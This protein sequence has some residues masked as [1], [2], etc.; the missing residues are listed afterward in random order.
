LRIKRLVALSDP[1]CGHRSGITPPG[2]WWPLRG[3]G[4]RHY[5]AI[6]QRETWARAK[7]AAIR[8][9]GC[10]LVVVNGDAIEGPGEKKGGVENIT[11]NRQEQVKMAVEYLKL[12]NAK[13]YV[14]AFGTPYH[15]GLTEDWEA[16]VAAEFGAEIR[17]MPFVEMNGV[18]FGFRHFVSASSIPHGVFTP[19][20]RERLWNILQAERKEQPRADVIIRSHVHSFAHC[21][22]AEWRAI[23]TPGL[24]GFGSSYGALKVSRCIDWG[25]I[26]F[27]IRGPGDYS[28]D[29]DVVR[30]VKQRA[31]V[32]HA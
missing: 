11:T 27:D 20:A 21:G 1:H 9:S 16:E 10:D 3:E 25:L 28:F 17:E 18:Y 23:I 22:N 7:Q 6:Q 15:G 31:R 14:F 24:Q 29:W 19:V 13:K 2:W 12:F 5:F 26:W 30:F 32:I 4:N 8:L